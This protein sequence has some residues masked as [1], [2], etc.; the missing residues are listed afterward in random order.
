MPNK[1]PLPAAIVWALDTAG[2][3]QQLEFVATSADGTQ[4]KHK[5]TSRLLG[6]SDESQQFEFK[7]RCCNEGQQHIKL[8]QV[9][10]VYNEFKARGPGSFLLCPQ[11]TPQQVRQHLNVRRP[12]A[13]HAGLL[14]FLSSSPYVV[15]YTECAI[16]DYSWWHGLVD[17]YFPKH[18]LVVQW[19]GEH[20]FDVNGTGMYR[21]GAAAQQSSDIRFNSLAWQSGL[22][23]LRLHYKDGGANGQAIVRRVLAWCMQNPGRKLLALSYSYQ[24]AWVRVVNA[25][26]VLEDQQYHVYMAKLLAAHKHVDSHLRVWLT[27]KVSGGRSGL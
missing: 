20:H 3:R 23:V 17:V 19:D 8:C 18:K 2:N 1:K 25:Q 14:S 4:V 5:R 12:S 13:R 7:Y 26:Q 27:Q 9:Q 22:R 6:C 11:C 24:S 10:A 16:K 15:Y 21:A